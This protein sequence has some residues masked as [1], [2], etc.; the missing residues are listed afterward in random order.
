MERLI[1]AWHL[2]RYLR[3]QICE[4]IA[5]PIADMVVSDTECA[6]RTRPTINF[7]MGGPVDSQYQSKKQRRKIIW[8]AAVRDRINTVSARGDTTIVLSIDGP[9]TFPPINPTRVITP[10]Y[11]ALILTVCI[12]GFDVHRVLVDPGSAA[13]LLHLSAFKQMKILVD[14][15]RLLAGFY[16]VSMELPH[17]QLVTS[18]FPSR[19]VR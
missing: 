1:R 16:Q 5:A 15:L 3:E 9:I 13:N 8:A 14:H 10:H 7:I 2:R 19:L 12:N 17:C 18:P 6:S 11:N 4:A